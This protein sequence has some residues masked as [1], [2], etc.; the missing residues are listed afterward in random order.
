M[1]NIQHADMIMKE[2]ERE[3]DGER[4]ETALL[5]WCTDGHGLMC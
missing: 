3:A 4:R 2:S 5:A 1:Q